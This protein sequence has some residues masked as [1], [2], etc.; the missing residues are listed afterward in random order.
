MQN[1]KYLIFVVYC[2]LTSQ[3]F[4][5]ATDGRP[6]PLAEV[7]KEAGDIKNPAARQ[8]VVESVR[9]KE[10]EHRTAAMVRAQQA[11]LSLRVERPD[12]HVYELAEFYDDTP[13]YRTTLNANAAISSG[14]N[15]LTVVPYSVDG[16]SSIIG[17][18]DAGSV[19]I[20]HQEFGGRVTSIDGAAAVD[21]S[22]HVGGTI[23]AAGVVSSAKGMAPAVYINSYDWNSDLSEMIEAGASYPGESGK[24]YISTHS[25]GY[26]AGWAY[27]NTEI[28]WEWWGNGTDA[29][30]V[31]ND[32]GMYSTHSRDIDTLSYNLPYYQIFWAAGNDRSEN[33]GAGDSVALSP[34]GTAVS[35]NPALHPPGDGIYRS[36][37]DTSSFHA[38]AKNVITVG[39]VTDAVSGGLRSAATATINSFSSYGPTDDGRIKPDIVANGHA[40]YSSRASGD[41][42]YYTSSGTS[43]ATP[44]AAGTAQLLVEW[45][46]SLFPGH[47]MRASTLKALLIHTADDKGNAGPD[48][49]YGWGLINGQKAADLLQDYRSYPNTQR[50]VEDRLSTSRRS[51][52]V[53]FKW[54]GVTP[55]RATLCW[56]DPAGASTTTGDSRTVRLVNNLDLRVIATDSSEFEPWVMPFVGD[57]SVASCAYP[58]VTGSNNTDNVEQVLIDSP[59]ISGIYQARVTFAGTL[60]NGS[61]PFSLILSGVDKTNIAPRPVL[62]SS[63]PLTG[64]GS[65]LFTLT[66]DHIMSGATLRLTRIGVADRPLT[67]IELTGD[68]I[69]ARADTSD[70][71]SGWWNL[72]VTN[73]DGQRATLYNAFVVP[74][75][76]WSEDFETEDIASRGWTTLAD[77]GVSQWAI[78]TAKS[79]SPTRS[80]F[81]PAVATRSDTALISPTLMINAAA[82]DLQ[83]SFWHDFSFENGRD[84]GVLEFSLDEGAWFDVMSSESGAAFSANGYNGTI[85][86]PGKPANAN[87]LN[88]R[89]A[90]TNTSGGF[91]QVVVALTDTAKYAGHSLKMRWRLGTDSS[92]A[93]T[94]WYVDDVMLSGIGA[95]LPPPLTGT[96]IAIW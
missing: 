42:A 20:T 64:S 74:D 24:L 56:S 30:A 6:P 89:Q 80:M 57:W 60:S 67:N 15:L 59:A 90:W 2:G 44:N 51:V 46:D 48:Y 10:K 54:D 17:I 12:G 47:V 7:I 9:K 37:Y 29:G 36:G 53:N 25:Y 16:S 23:G 45:Y 22:T 93:G 96:V 87:P 85:N 38:L 95:P 21:H 94:G 41:T 13:L 52:S 83:I 34:G 78:S 4:A 88:S 32:F 28:K 63:T 55:I 86:T 69:K 79:V 26:F 75:T 27:I 81:S 65:L 5:A 19:R 76:I 82:A 72:R 1:L 62:T 61:Q 31:E 49:T 92:T 91:Q 68:T 40:L 14:A 70:M 84:G 35:Y 50:V 66:T 8:R 73:P 18:W 11:G 3:L 39:S 43:M 77:Q 33:P 71:A 58:A